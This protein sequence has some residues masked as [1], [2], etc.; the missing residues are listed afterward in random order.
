MPEARVTSYQHLSSGDKGRPPTSSSDDGALSP[1]SKK[2]I[3]ECSFKIIT[4]HTKEPRSNFFARPPSSGIDGS[5]FHFARPTLPRRSFISR[6]QTRPSPQKPVEDKVQDNNNSDKAVSPITSCVKSSLPPSVL[7]CEAAKPEENPNST[8]IIHGEE[9]GEPNLSSG[10]SCQGQGEDLDAS[11]AITEP[12]PAQQTLTINTGCQQSYV[13]AQVAASSPA[14]PT[15]LRDEEIS[16]TLELNDENHGGFEDPSQQQ[17]ETKT[18]SPTPISDEEC[19]LNS[20]LGLINDGG[21]CESRQQRAKSTSRSPSNR[22]SKRQTPKPPDSPTTR[23]F[24]GSFMGSLPS[25]EDLFALLL[26]KLKKR[27]KAEAAR[28]IKQE[29]MKIQLHQTNEENKTL[30]TAL[31][32]AEQHSSKREADKE[33]QQ[34]LIERWKS[35]F[36]RMRAIMTSIENDQEALHRDG[37]VIKKT[38]LSLKA[39]HH[40]IYTN[41][42]HV[43]DSASW[44]GEKWHQHKTQLSSIRH[45]LTTLDQAL[46]SA[47]DKTSEENR[48]LKEEKNRVMILES[49]IKS[50]S[51]RTLRQSTE[52]HRTQQQ[53]ASRLE[54][55]ASIVHDFWN[56]SHASFRDEL[57]TNLDACLQALDKLNE[58]GAVEPSHLHSLD[59]TIRESSSFLR[60]FV[61]ESAKKLDA[62]AQAQNDQ[63]E[64]IVSKLK[65]VESSVQSSSSAACQ[66]TNAQEINGKLQGQ[67]GAAEAKLSQALTDYN[68]AKVTEDA[69]KTH[70]ADLQHELSQSKEQFEHSRLEGDAKVSELQRRL[71]ETTSTLNKTIENL[72]SKQLEF[73]ELEQA[74][75]ESTVKLEM[76]EAKVSC[77][78]SEKAEAEEKSRSTE[79]RVREELTRESLK[80]KDQNRAWFEQEKHKL[81]QEKLRAK[82]DSIVAKE[83]L[84][85]IK[86][87]LAETQCS[88]LQLMT[89][90]ENQKKELEAMNVAHQIAES[91][92]AK[93]ILDLKE[94][95]SISAQE[96]SALYTQLVA[97][98][99][100]CQLVK[101]ELCS[102]HESENA[103]NVD[104]SRM[105]ENQ[106]S[107]VAEELR[108]KDEMLADVRKTFDQFQEET[109]KRRLEEASI[110]REQHAEA[111]VK[112][113]KLTEEL[114]EK[115][116]QVASLQG[117]IDLQNQS[118]NIIS[119]LKQTLHCRESE[120]DDLRSKVENSSIV[121]EQIESILQ[122][123]GLLDT[124][125]NVR[126]SVPS[127]EA[128]LNTM[129]NKNRGENKSQTSDTRG[130]AIHGGGRAKRKR[131]AP[132]TPNGDDGGYPINR[133]EYQ[134][135]EV[136]Y[137]THSITGSAPVSP[138]KPSTLPQV[139]PQNRRTK[140]QTSFIRPFSKVGWDSNEE[141]TSPVLL[142]ATTDIP[143]CSIQDPVNEEM[144]LSP[145]KGDIKG[146]LGTNVEPNFA[147]PASAHHDS[148]GD[149]DKRNEGTKSPLNEHLK[150]KKTQF[151]TSEQADKSM[152]ILSDANCSRVEIEISP[153]THPAQGGGKKDTKVGT[154]GKRHPEHRM[155][156]VPLKGI[157]KDTVVLTPSSAN[158]SQQ[159]CTPLKESIT[160]H[161]S[162]PV[163]PRRQSR[164]SS[165]FFDP[166]IS[167]NPTVSITYSNTRE[168]RTINRSVDQFMSQSR[169]RSRRKR[170]G[171]MYNDRFNKSYSLR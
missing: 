79:L 170:K 157:L 136:I 82:K 134:T 24:A 153:K 42:K 32:E 2:I 98:Q 133:Q 120:I 159:A 20:E 51:T 74:L 128:I 89:T 116:S 29:E 9:D 117:S 127:L 41:I 122:K 4:P 30:K 49:Y 102:K 151:R 163:A 100:E 12:H 23:R 104:R 126:D 140:P 52:I 103:E 160:Q 71:E 130:G 65:A 50:C 73:E 35:K 150:K 149:A 10:P 76:T 45:E 64:M 165:R 27:E 37:D 96:K 69:L 145:F 83:Q 164:V 123:F 146:G 70:L 21:P 156:Q 110:S 80:T 39:E 88:N 44:A 13:V 1:N 25:E 161:S 36:S 18:A 54:A 118:T 61:E 40:R 111:E 144:V 171:E 119:E 34:K 92:Y 86:A 143:D 57:K 132:I 158:H 107:D 58:R 19:H 115:V 169:E 152:S 148:A 53:M 155:G 55:V 129:M 93:E 101:T 91:G 48:A 16:M 75:K 72:Q 62:S 84:E 113:A 105:L 139:T 124:G 66:L 67:L 162:F 109:Q 137:R 60:N 168:T 68:H 6:P 138:Y 8:F 167:P 59:S 47:R 90:V 11:P 78:E 95:Q 131:I 94:A 87:S 56:T 166:Q 99:A 14:A 97:A 112:I 15:L 3:E 33:A 125:Q 142:V 22:V 141:V 38:L 135:T 28:A 106:L 26:H 114:G 77:L 81:I 31:N 5:S 17:E 63:V 85:S 121:Q 46:Q 154:A 147:S 108:H 43:Q 7:Y